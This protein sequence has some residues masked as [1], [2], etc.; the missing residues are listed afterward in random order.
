[1]AKFV[2]HPLYRFWETS[3]VS[4]SSNQLHKCDVLIWCINCVSSFITCFLKIHRCCKG[5]N[6]HFCDIFCW[7]IMAWIRTCVYKL[8][9]LV[10]NI[11]FLKI[12]RCCKGFYHFCDIFSDFLCYIIMAWIRT[13][14]CTSSVYCRSLCNA[15]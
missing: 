2:W 13:C 5:L 14:V 9:I 7:N 6:Y 12:H 8:C 10:H 4:A 1:M 15:S 3:T 11:C